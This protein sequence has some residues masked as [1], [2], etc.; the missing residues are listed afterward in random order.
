MI[1]KTENMDGARQFLQFMRSEEA[2]VILQQ[3]GYQ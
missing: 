2:Q 3:Y 1:G